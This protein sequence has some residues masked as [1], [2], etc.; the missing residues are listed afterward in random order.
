MALVVQIQSAAVACSLLHR[1][2]S[3]VLTL[4]FGVAPKINVKTPELRRLFL[5]HLHTGKMEC[6]MG[7]LLMNSQSSP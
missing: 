4:I 5:K 7:P 2:N 1:R 3:G 6:A